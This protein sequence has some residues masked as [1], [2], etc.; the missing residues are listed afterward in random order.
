[1][2]QEEVYIDTQIHIARIETARVNISVSTLK[3][4][5]DYFDITLSDFFKNPQ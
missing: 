2:T 5:C 3:A 4:L 1:L